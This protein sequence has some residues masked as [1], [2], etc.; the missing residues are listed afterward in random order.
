MAQELFS[1]ESCAFVLRLREVFFLSLVAVNNFKEIFMRRAKSVSDLVKDL[2]R[3]NESLQR[4]VKVANQYTKLEFGYTV[5]EIHELIRR[6]KLYEKKFPECG[7]VPCDE[8][9]Q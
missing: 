5:K 2:Q 6:V 8:T 9:P 7:N 3:E 4:L 1:V